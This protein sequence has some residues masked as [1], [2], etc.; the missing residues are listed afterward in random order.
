[1]RS[2]SGS[3][4]ACN[5]ARTR[6]S[7]ELQTSLLPMLKHQLE[8]CRLAIMNPRPAAEWMK[9]EAELRKATGDTVRLPRLGGSPRKP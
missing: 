8:E 7:F 3:S 6:S 1:M 9:R 4:A 5:S 2:T